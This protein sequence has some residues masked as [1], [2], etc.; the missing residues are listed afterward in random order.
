VSTVGCK[1]NKIN[2]YDSLYSNISPQT[3]EQIASLLFLDNAD[4]IEVC[5]PPVAQQTNGTD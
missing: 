5:I 1:G 3:E 2:L 4:H